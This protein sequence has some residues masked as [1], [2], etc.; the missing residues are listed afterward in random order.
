VLMQ[1][2]K[3]KLHILQLHNIIDWNEYSVL[4]MQ[5][6]TFSGTFYRLFGAKIVEYIIVHFDIINFHTSF[7]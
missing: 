1:C 4:P 6:P 2:L 5:W 7:V 3:Q